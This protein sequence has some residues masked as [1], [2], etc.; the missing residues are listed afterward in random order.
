MT[1]KVYHVADLVI[2]IPNLVH[3]DGAS[4]DPWAWMQEQSRKLSEPDAAL[5]NEPSPAMHADFDTL[6]ETITST[7]EPESWDDRGG[8]GV[9]APHEANL[10]LVIS[11]TAEI[12]EQIAEL[13]EK[14]RRGLDVQI[15]VEARFVTA[16]DDFFET[17]GV[18]LDVI[19]PV[20]RPVAHAYIGEDGLERI[21]VDFDVE[22]KESPTLREI[23]ITQSKHAILSDPQLRAFLAAVQNHRLANVVAAP[24]LTT[25]N[26]QRAF[27][28][29]DLA[30]NRDAQ[31]SV[32][33]KL[34][35]P[36]NSVVERESV[37]LAVRG[38]A[39]NDR[40]EVRLSVAPM[41]SQSSQAI[42]AA[43]VYVASLPEHHNVSQRCSTVTAIVPVG[44]SVLVKGVVL[45]CANDNG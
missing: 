6:I 9:I 11:Q 23:E 19:D 10:S 16:P 8:P 27:V 26:G 17:L 35:K 3:G 18:D 42:A 15:V 40:R 36:R 44:C 22:N 4:P 25:F 31:P 21:G 7:V 37:A 30:A 14:M 29:F 20:I 1:T 13:L 12:H 32:L 33:S 2:P 24:K 43:P 28:A 45:A 38:V 5:A 39:S 41:I 34:R